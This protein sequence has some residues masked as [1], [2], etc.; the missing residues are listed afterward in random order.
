MLVF[1]LEYFLMMMVMFSIS[2]LT[3]IILLVFGLV[4]ANN[5]WINQEKLY[6]ADEEKSKADKLVLIIISLPIVIIF[7]MLLSYVIR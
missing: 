6:I 5:W 3:A 4:G 7:L 1:L 2:H